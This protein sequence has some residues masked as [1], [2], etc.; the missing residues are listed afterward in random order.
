MTELLLGRSLA[1]W[2]ACRSAGV[3]ARVPI[4]CAGISTSYW[5]S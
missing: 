4:R 2:Q 1:R 3:I 5:Q